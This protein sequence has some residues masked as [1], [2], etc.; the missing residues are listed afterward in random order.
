MRIMLKYKA[1]YDF[2]ALIIA[3]I[4]G[5]SASFTTTAI[6]SFGA[7]LLAISVWLSLTG[8]LL[9]REKGYYVSRRSVRGALGVVFTAISIALITAP[10][11][12]RIQ[13]IIILAG[14]GLA[15]VYAYYLE[16]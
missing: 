9:E 5:I 8:V 15:G 6:K 3:V 12:F 14:L 10:I 2:L 16:K 7:G 1:L 4:I 13:L 11:D